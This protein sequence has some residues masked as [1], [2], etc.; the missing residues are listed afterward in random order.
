MCCMIA[1]ALAHQ[2]AVDPS[3]LSHVLCPSPCHPHTAQLCAADGTRQVN[4]TITSAWNIVGNEPIG[5]PKPIQG[6][7]KNTGRNAPQGDVIIVDGYDIM[8]LL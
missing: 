7:T 3:V 1:G 5:T 8:D 4:L 2:T 6:N